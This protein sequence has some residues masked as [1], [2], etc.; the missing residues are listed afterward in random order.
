MIYKKLF[1][2]EFNKKKFI[3]FLDENN[4][5]TFLEMNEKGEYEYCMLE[6]FLVLSK[7]FNCNNPYLA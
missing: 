6:D 1:G 3:I 2:I 7:I 5:R 4:R